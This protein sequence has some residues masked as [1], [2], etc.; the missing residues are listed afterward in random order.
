MIVKTEIIN[1]RQIEIHEDSVGPRRYWAKIAGKALFQRGRMRLRTFTTID[2]ARDAAV[3]AI[4]LMK[5]QPRLWHVRRSANARTHRGPRL[6]WLAIAV[7]GPKQVTLVRPYAGRI[8]FKRTELARWLLSET[9]EA[10]IAAFR[11]RAALWRENALEDLR[12]AE[13]DLAYADHRDVESALRYAKEM[14]Q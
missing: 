10:A 6:Y 4:A 11:E 3:E 5:D 1:G 7:N 12:R 13:R 9:P 8:A 2:G 14:N